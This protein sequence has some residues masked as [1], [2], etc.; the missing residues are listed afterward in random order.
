MAA[1]CPVCGALA[2][3]PWAVV[4]GFAILECA[5]CGFAQ[6]AE[7]P[8]SD[9]TERVYGDAYF[10][11]GGAGYPG[12]EHLEPALRRT[13]RW[14]GRLL[15]QYGPA[16][17]VLDIGSAA[18]FLLQGL[19][20]V[21]WRGVGLE[22]NGRMCAFARERLGLEVRQGAIEAF[23]PDRLYD[24]VLWVQVIGHVRDLEAA[25]ER[26]RAATRRGGL[27]LIETWNRSSWQARL[28]GSRWHHYAPPSVRRWFDPR[29]L[30]ALLRRW[31]FELLRV[32]RPPKRTVGRHLRALLE[33]H[34]ARWPLR[35]FWRALGRLLPERLV[36]PYPGRDVFYALFRRFACGWGFEV[37]LQNLAVEWASIAVVL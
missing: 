24:A 5:G 1:S 12:Y 37:C 27:W 8:E 29:T 32:G 26:A 30:S 22:P 6:L 25:L 21:G 33:H 11:A 3:R 23:E 13:G 14:Y 16:G 36:I 2:W 4:R 20:E 28:W 19:Q 10:S 34:S 9:Y 17:W 7:E 15:R 18:G 35:G 31:D